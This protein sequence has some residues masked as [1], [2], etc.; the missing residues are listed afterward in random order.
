MFLSQIFWISITKAHGHQQ[1]CERA[2]GFLAFLT[3]PLR[4]EMPCL[5]IH[6]Q[7]VD[8]R[9]ISSA[10][11][12]QEHADA[13]CEVTTNW[14]QWSSALSRIIMAE[15]AYTTIHLSSRRLDHHV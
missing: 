15:V 7:S 10:A 1:P 2:G 12:P 6:T 11:V 5:D 4:H 9:A 13:F 14:N 3:M 8:W